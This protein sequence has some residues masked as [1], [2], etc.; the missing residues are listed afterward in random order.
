MKNEATQSEYCHQNK[1][2]MSDW[3]YHE[4]NLTQ[5]F[6][7]SFSGN[8]SAAVYTANLLSSFYSRQRANN[9]VFYNVNCIYASIRNNV[10]NYPGVSGSCVAFDRHRFSRKRELFSPC[11]HFDNT[12]VL[13]EQDLGKIYNYTSSS[14]LHYTEW[15]TKFKSKSTLVHT[16]DVRWGHLIPR[17]NATTNG[18][19]LNT[20]YVFVQ[21]NTGSWGPP[22]FDCNRTSRWL[23]T[24]SV[25]FFDHEFNFM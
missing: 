20:S 14:S 17:L 11:A 2:Q 5:Q 25:P 9:S 13:I 8:A 19:P 24:Y 10:E 16:V 4:I 18:E 15:F 3:N 22:Y 1:D 21:E 7:N 6:Y 12:G 23:V